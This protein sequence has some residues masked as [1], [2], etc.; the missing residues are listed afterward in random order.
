MC[1]ASPNAPVISVGGLA[2]QYLIPGWRLG[3][4]LM[5]DFFCVGEVIVGLVGLGPEDSCHLLL[6]ILHRIRTGLVPNPGD[7]VRRA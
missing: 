1:L 3:W 5:Y 4:I 7:R 6:R 2:K